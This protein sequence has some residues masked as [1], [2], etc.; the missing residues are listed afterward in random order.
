MDR[1]G[2][3]CGT[4]ALSPCMFAASPYDL[5]LSSGLGYTPHLFSLYHNIIEQDCTLLPPHGTLP[6]APRRT[7]FTACVQHNKQA[8]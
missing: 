1:K 4:G 6:R 2:G 3:S 7:R 5:L 8:A